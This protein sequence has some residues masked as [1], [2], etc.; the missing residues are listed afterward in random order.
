MQGPQHGC[1][2]FS[3]PDRGLSLITALN[4]K[5]F[6]FRSWLMTVFL[7]FVFAFG[8]SARSDVHS[9]TLL[10]PLSIIFLG[11]VLITL[12]REHLQQSK[13]LFLAII[14]VFFVTLF[15]VIPLPTSVWNLLSKREG[16]VALV[17]KTFNLAGQWRPLALSP[18]DALQTFSSLA[19]PA[20]IVLLGIQMN[21]FERY[22]LLP[23]LMG[24]ATISGLIG[25]LQTISDPNGALF[26]YSVTNNG[27]AVGLFANRNHAATL[28]A[29]LFPM[30]AVFAVT[31]NGKSENRNRFRLLL[32]LGLGMTLVPLIMVTGSRLGFLLAI[33]GLAAGAFLYSEGSKGQASNNGRTLALVGLIV[34]C[35]FVL[36][37][38]F[39]RATAFSRFFGEETSESRSEFLSVSKNILWEFLPLGTGPASFSSAYKVFEPTRYLDPTY[40]NHAHNDWIE[41]GVTFG[42]PGIFIVILATAGYS[43]QTFYLWRRQTELNRPTFFGRM[44]GVMIGLIAISSLTDYPLR[45]PIF[46]SVFAICLVWFARREKSSSDRFS[47]PQS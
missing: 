9:L 29:C 20:A 47:G 42:L 19:I 12:R 3:D 46:M 32:L 22:R 33:I 37:L 23:I 7:L 27:S 8:G 18:T 11:V 17:L 14:C 43:L 35:L 10:N 28:L 4:I 45:T 6:S 24:L 40:L 44:G 38:A 1:D 5:K 16:V 2:T 15:Y 25:I 13:I 39:S 34:S 36:T 21:K 26:F 41:T 31:D 30:L